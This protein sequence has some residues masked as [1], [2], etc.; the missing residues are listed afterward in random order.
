MPVIHAS[1]VSDDA[2][3]MS[4]MDSPT[5]PGTATTKFGNNDTAANATKHTAAIDCSTKAARSLPFFACAIDAAMHATKAMAKITPAP[6]IPGAN[7]GFTTVNAS[8]VATTNSTRA[9][10]CHTRR[11]FSAR[12][13]TA[14]VRSV[15][16]AT[17][18]APAAMHIA[19][20]SAP[21]TSVNGESKPSSGTPA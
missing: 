12:P 4:V 14:L 19:N 9:P 11:C 8:T 13:C 1:D 15:F 17:H 6:S 2:A 10:I 18:A 16:S 3:L 7:C 21:T 5:L 20:P